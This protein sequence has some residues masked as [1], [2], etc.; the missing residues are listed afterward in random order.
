MGNHL[1]QAPTYQLLISIVCVCVC[2]YKRVN[3]SDFS[4]MLFSVDQ[5]ACG[6]GNIMSNLDV[7]LLNAKI[8]SAWL[9]VENKSDL[10]L[11]SLFY[12]VK[13]DKLCKFDCIGPNSRE[14][15]SVLWIWE[16]LTGNDVFTNFLYIQRPFPVTSEW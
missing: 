3:I 15:T 16:N 9:F 6:Q 14:W 12:S 1:T 13:S 4:Q 7:L 11:T 2:V 10:K 8:N 5:R